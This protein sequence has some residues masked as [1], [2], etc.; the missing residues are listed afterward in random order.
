MRTLVRCVIVHVVFAFALLLA[1]TRN[2][3]AQSAPGFALGRYQPSERGSDWFVGESLDLRGRW[4][5]AVGVVMDE[6]YRSLV[7]YE[8]GETRAVPVRHMFF[9]HVG[10][11]LV[12]ASRVRVAASLPVLLFAEGETATVA[13]T[14]YEAPR[15]AQGIG[16]LRLGADVRIFGN[17]GDVVTGAVGVQLWTPT[18]SRDQYT[19]DGAVRLRGRAMIAGDVAGVFTYAA[20]LGAGWH[21]R[22]ERVVGGS[23]GS[24]L[25]FVISAGARLVGRRMVVG[26][27]VHGTTAFS[28]PF[29]RLSTPLEALLG[30]H[31]DLH[32]VRLGAGVGTGLTR[33]LGAPALRAL[34]SVEWA[35]NVAP[36]PGSSPE[37]AV[38]PAPPA[39]ELAADPRPRPAPFD[40]DADGVPDL[41]DACPTVA[42]LKEAEPGRIGCPDPD[43]DHDGVLDV[44]DACPDVAGPGHVDPTRNGCPNAF[45]RGDRIQTLEPV[46]FAPGSAAIV[47]GSSA[48]EVLASILD[49]LR[50]HPEIPGLLVEGHTD[51]RGRAELNRSLSVARAAA[52]VRWF[53]DRGIEPQRL[54]SQGFGP[55]RPIDSNETEGGRRKNR[56]VEFHIARPAEGTSEAPLTP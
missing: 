32:G 14:T 8:D 4:R 13:G 31:Y 3:H 11:S 9:G 12:L 30:A 46:M 41:D 47:P 44:D 20:Q 25:G 51:D 7:A 17:Y 26:P 52:I 36:A 21:A 40:V 56:R 39:A 54:T 6:S 19:S 29:G 1:A 49:V 15:R 27:E 55:D 33:G 50:K 18:G 28:D 43:P 35:P 5:P 34:L 37:Q 2:A 45:V 16:D 22:S 42:G 24:E 38:P 10:A 23:I 53:T 48:E